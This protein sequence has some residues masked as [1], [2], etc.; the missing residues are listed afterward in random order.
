MFESSIP[1]VNTVLWVVLAYTKQ[2]WYYYIYKFLREGGNHKEFER[3]LLS[4]KGRRCKQKEKILEL[5]SQRD[6]LAKIWSII[7]DAQF[8][9][10]FFFFC[11]KQLNF[12]YT[13]RKEISLCNI[14][15]LEATDDNYKYLHSQKLSASSQNSTKQRGVRRTFEDIT[16]DMFPTSIL[17][18]LFIST[19]VSRNGTKR[20]LRNNTK[21]S[22]GM[23]WQSLLKQWM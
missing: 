8:M 13:W 4:A 9:F 17:V 5:T 23:H 1:L 18:F 3:L 11:D 19:G 15:T 6:C 10:F 21:C 12:L 14:T 7:Y 2:R 22:Y 16:I 20:K